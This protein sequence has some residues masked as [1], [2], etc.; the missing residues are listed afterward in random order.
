[1]KSTDDITSHDM[2]TAE[3]CI[4][5]L[6]QGIYL[7]CTSNELEFFVI[8]S[9]IKQKS[10]NILNVVVMFG[11][12]MVKHYLDFDKHLVEFAIFNKCSKIFI[13]A[14]PGVARFAKKIGYEEVKY[15]YKHIPM[16]KAIGDSTQV[17]A[18]GEDAFS[19]EPRSNS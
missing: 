15:K 7:L 17:F 12:N 11:K 16:V 13:Q 2:V 4:Y 10:N 5:R 14:R 19:A 6:K 9:I 1:M 8:V 18:Q 3:E